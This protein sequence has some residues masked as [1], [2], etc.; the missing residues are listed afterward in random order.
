VNVAIFGATG[1]VGAGVLLECLDDARVQTVLVVARRSTGQR[2]AKLTEVLIDDF[3]NYDALTRHFAR[4]DA[5]FFCLGVTSA[6]LDES[7]YTRLTHDL[8]LAAAEA[9]L[10]AAARKNHLVFCFVSGMGTDATEKGRTM[11]ARVKG[12][13]ENALRSLP[14]RAAYMLRPGFIEPLRGVRSSTGW[15][16]AFYVVGRPFFPLMR[17]LFPRQV[18]S[19][20]NIGRAMIALVEKGYARTVLD[21]ADINTL[22]NN[23]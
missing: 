18:T 2:H 13:T 22:A 23:T 4:L 20:V 15:Y 19:T 10:A 8:T 12:R 5:C 6:G 9:M 3:F 1:M 11:W 7:E 17:R 14:F 21:P 16:R